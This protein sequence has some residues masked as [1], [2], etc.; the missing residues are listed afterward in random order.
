MDAYQY[1]QLLNCVSETMTVLARIAEALE[2]QAQVLAFL[3]D[4]LVKL[5]D[6]LEDTLARL[7]PI[8]NSLELLDNIASEL[9]TARLEQE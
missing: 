7:E 9:Q 3:N 5:N 4:N 1:A 8:S 2:G 6:T